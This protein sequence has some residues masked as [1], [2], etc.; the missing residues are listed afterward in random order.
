M[1]VQQLM[2]HDPPTKVQQLSQSKDSGGGIGC[3]L[4]DKQQIITGLLDYIN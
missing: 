4:E 2:V 3:L 1:M